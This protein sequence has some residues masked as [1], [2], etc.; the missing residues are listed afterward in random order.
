MRMEMRWAVVLT[1]VLGLA[2]SLAGAQPPGP[3]PSPER[4]EW[5][6]RYGRYSGAL[7]KKDYKTF[8][9]MV[10]PDAAWML[11]GGKKLNPAQMQ[12]EF[13]RKLKAVG[14]NIQFTMNIT[15]LTVNPKET[16]VERT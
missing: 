10:A 2:G 5:N 9:Q 16:V 6:E 7:L 12:A 3:A 8:R 1:A 11:T 4:K 14:P 13:A 15:K